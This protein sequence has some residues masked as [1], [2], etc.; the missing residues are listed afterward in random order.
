MTGNPWIPCAEQLPPEGLVVETRRENGA[1]E[2]LGRWARLVRKGDKWYF[3]EMQNVFGRSF[4]PTH[5]RFVE[6]ANEP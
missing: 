6:E 2:F 5:W 1:D 4:P 3:E